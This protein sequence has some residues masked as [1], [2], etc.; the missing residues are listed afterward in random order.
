MRKLFYI[1]L[2]L[3]MIIGLSSYTKGAIDGMG[4]EVRLDF[5]ETI[6]ELKDRAELNIEN[7]VLI[8]EEEYKK[9][10]DLVSEHGPLHDEYEE[11]VA[12]KLFDVYRFI[13]VSIEVDGDR[14]DKANS[15]KK[16]LEKALFV[17]G[18]DIE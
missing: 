18:F 16:E 13:V 1:V 15:A 4:E 17:A 3:L 8:S 10:Y 11:D 6:F 7:R 14:W 2:V 12:Y 9:I 5:Y